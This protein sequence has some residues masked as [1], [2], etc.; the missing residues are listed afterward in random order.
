MDSYTIPQE[1]QKLITDIQ[2]ELLRGH[3]ALGD[4]RAAFLKQESALAKKIEELSDNYTTTLSNIA[5]SGGV[6]LKKEPWTFNVQ[7]M[8]FTKSNGQQQ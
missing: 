8:T 5:K 6:D 4:L 2:G 3:A 7:T 1:M